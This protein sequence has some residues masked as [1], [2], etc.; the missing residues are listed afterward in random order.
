MNDASPP[1]NRLT[2]YAEIVVG[3][4]G[5]SLDKQG[6]VITCEASPEIGFPLDDESAIFTFRCN[7]F[8]QSHVPE[9]SAAR[10]T[11]DCPESRVG[12][13]PQTPALWPDRPHVPSLQEAR[14]PRACAPRNPTPWRTPVRVSDRGHILVTAGTHRDDFGRTAANVAPDSPSVDAHL[15]E[16]TIGG[17]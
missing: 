1:R 2:T 5:A 8:L 10:A 3:Q 4:P 14:L 6:P 13:P 7:S 12:G 15:R 11:H 16:Q 9:D 17:Q